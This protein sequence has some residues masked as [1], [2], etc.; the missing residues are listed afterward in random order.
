[1]VLYVCVIL[2]VGLNGDFWV[3]W[4]SCLGMKIFKFVFLFYFM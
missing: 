4:D 3:V 2:W 1:M